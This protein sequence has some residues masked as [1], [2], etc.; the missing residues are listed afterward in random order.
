M[1]G[2]ETVIASI[3]ER[4][5]GW[6]AHLDPNTIADPN[7]LATRAKLTLPD[8]ERSF[9]ETE[10]IVL[11]MSSL[12]DGTIGELKYIGSDDYEVVLDWIRKAKC[13]LIERYEQEFKQKWDG[14]RPKDCSRHEWELL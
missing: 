5:N 11:K 6:L 13:A 3:G 8:L 14:P 4:R 2:L 12:Y 1:V 7:A 10:E 9:K